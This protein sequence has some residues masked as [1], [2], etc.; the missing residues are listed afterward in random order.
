MGASDDRRRVH[1]KS[2]SDLVERLDA[3]AALSDRDRTDLL[4]EAIR[5]YV[6]D[7]A[8]NDRFRALVAEAYYDGQL[9]DDEVETLVGTEHARRL[10]LLA[11]DLDA[12]PF[13]LDP[14]GEPD[15]YGEEVRTT[16]PGDGG[17]ASGDDGER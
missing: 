2:P 7:I 15:V 10:R 6:E 1:F 12:E 14:P 9:D 5:E 4:V 11:A 13:V 16:T 8:E 17:S 3:I